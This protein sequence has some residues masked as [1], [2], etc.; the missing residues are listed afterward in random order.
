MEA[1]FFSVSHRWLGFLLKREIMCCWYVSLMW[2]SSLEDVRVGRDFGFLMVVFKCCHCSGVEFYGCFLLSAIRVIFVLY[3][4]M[5]T[6]VFYYELLLY[7]GNIIVLGKY[8]TQYV[9][10]PTNW[11][12]VFSLKVSYNVQLYCIMSYNL[13]RYHEK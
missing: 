12:Q 5:N 11:D 7:V 13:V 9:E 10:W 1:G 2:R 3:S 8:L 6:I 4:Y